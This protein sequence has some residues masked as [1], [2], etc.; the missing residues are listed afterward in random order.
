MRALASFESGRTDELLAWLKH[1]QIPVEFRTIRQQNGLE[2][3]EI[4]VEEEAFDRGR[5]IV[6]EWYAEQ[7]RLRKS[8]FWINVIGTLLILSLL[9]ILFK[10]TLIV[11]ALLLML[12]LVDWT[13][14]YFAWQAVRTGIIHSRPLAEWTDEIERSKD[15]FG[16]WLR[17]VVCIL[18]GCFLLG[19]VIFGVTRLYRQYAS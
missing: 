10:P 4:L 15:P 12:V 6:E 11:F 16:F 8:Q 2:I 5:V 1:H 13:F 9:L 17:V 3:S 14:F 18:M 19:F 7:R